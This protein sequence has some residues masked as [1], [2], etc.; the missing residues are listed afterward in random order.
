MIFM[1]P[2]TEFSGE[3]LNF[4]KSKLASQPWETNFLRIPGLEALENNEEVFLSEAVAKFCP[5]AI[6]PSTIEAE[7]ERLQYVLVREQS[8]VSAECTTALTYFG[9]V[10]DADDCASK[11]RE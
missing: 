9:L 11:A 2:V 8:Q 6:S 4:M 5:R 1:V 7:A 3:E 10:V